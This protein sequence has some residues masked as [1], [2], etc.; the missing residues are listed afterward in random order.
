MS[1]KKSSKPSFDAHPQDSTGNVDDTCSPIE[2]RLPEDQVAPVPPEPVSPELGS[3]A[4]DWEAVD[5]P[6][7]VKVATTGLEASP[8]DS[9]QSEPAPDQG[10]FTAKREN[11]LLSLI[12]DLNECNDALLARISQTEGALENAQ[13]ALQME[14]ERAK[15]AQAKM[16][17]QMSAE[18]AS[19]QQISQTA[20]QQIAKLVSELDTTE[21]ALQRQ[22]LINETLQ[23]ELND[24]QERV[25]QLERE[26]ALISQQ[27]AE[28]AQ[29]RIKAETVSRDLRSRLQRQQRYTLQFKAALEKSLTVKA[30]PVYT[31]SVAEA[32]PV[33]YPNAPSV[34]MPRAQRIMPWVAAGSS[35]FT[36]ID[37]HLETLIRNASTPASEPVLLNEP[38]SSAAAID[39][40]AEDKLWQ[41]LER[42]MS[43]I[44]ET[45]AP[46]TDT[47]SP[48]AVPTENRDEAATSP[49]P[50]STKLNWQAA[51]Q[52]A[53]ATETKPDT[54][55]E[56]KPK[57]PSTAIEQQ[58]A[59]AIATRVEESFA[60]ATGQSSAEEI[61]FTE[62]SPWGKPL[63]ETTLPETTLPE[64]TEEAAVGAAVKTTVNQPADYSPL[65][66]NQAGSTVSPLVKPERSP[67][68]V[69]SMAAVQ[70]PTFER[71]KAG[72][73]KR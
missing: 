67:K 37:P 33:S 52:L 26:S 35:S 41:D 3:E 38:S 8:V 59:E 39:P 70:L 71:A 5:L 42:V 25:T 10:S 69:S 21:Q 28:A 17:E 68:K 51:A 64:T 18:Q 32:Q 57:E 30:R 31:A 48:S 60:A 29:A 12:H 53:R 20:Q 4:S 47:V 15:A 23:A 56:I 24:H 36:G 73:F 9:A 54:E 62:P 72:S 27:H 46:A 49:T 14:V 22:Q 43:R 66:N 11:E 19:V 55:P 61:G 16:I 50:K 58:P 40:E 13:S 7:T 63:P 44:D 34:T 45:P 1:K 65:M 2:G 6:G